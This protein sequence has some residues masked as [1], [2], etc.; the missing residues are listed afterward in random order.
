MIDPLE[1]NRL[2][3][4]ILAEHD[5]WLAKLARSNVSINNCEDFEQEIRMAFWKNLESYDGQISDLAKRFFSVAINTAK[6]FRRKDGRMRKNEEYLYPNSIFVEQ[7]R[8]QINIIEEFTGKL[9]ELD[10]QVF[11]MYIDD[12][13][14]EDMSAALGCNEVN[15]RKRV[16]RIKEQFKKQFIGR[17]LD[18]TVP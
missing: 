6:K 12:T 4:E 10:R 9:G 14:Y 2:F 7:E 1:K 3:E 13:R 8:D 15:L 18:Q 5:C 17:D 16:S 11:T